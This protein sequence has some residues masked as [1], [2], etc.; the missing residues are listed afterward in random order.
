L[1]CLAFFCFLVLQ[2]CIVSW[3]V[4]YILSCR[5]WS[6]L[7]LS[8]LILSCFVLPCLILSCIVLSCLVFCLVWSCLLS[9]C[10][11]LSCLPS[12]VVCLI[13]RA[14]PLSLIRSVV[15][16]AEVIW[17]NDGKGFGFLS[18]RPTSGCLRPRIYICIYICICICIRISI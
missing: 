9:S 8:C 11:V 14:F 6:Y 16:P 13:L 5:V 18:Q 15:L 4:I 17:F 7:V 3:R 10:L 2:C 12:Y 1:S